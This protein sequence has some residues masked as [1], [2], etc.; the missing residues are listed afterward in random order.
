M[1]SVLF[2]SPQPYFQWRGSPIR[3]RFVLQAFSELGYQ[4]DLLTL[5]FGED[6]DLPNVSIT[7]VPNIYRAKDV[8]IGPSLMKALFDIVILFKAISM[9]RSKHYDVIHGIEEGGF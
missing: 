5:P 3:V 6:T 9:L 2:I 7:R 8:A 4:V 1:K